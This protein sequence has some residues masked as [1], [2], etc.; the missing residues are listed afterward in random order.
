[1]IRSHNVS[2]FY[3]KVYSEVGKFPFSLHASRACFSMSCILTAIR[4]LS[5][6]EMCCEFISCRVPLQAQLFCDSEKFMF[7]DIIEVLEG[8]HLLKCYV[9]KPNFL[10]SFLPS[11]PS[12]IALSYLGAISAVF[13]CCYFPGCVPII[14]ICNTVSTNDWL[15]TTIYSLKQ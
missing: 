15:F 4:H 11:Y 8:Y 6:P 14:I 10:P 13:A 2:L 12:R 9:S 5:E 3:G 7:S 1:M